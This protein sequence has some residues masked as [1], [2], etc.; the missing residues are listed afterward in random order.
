MVDPQFVN[1]ETEIR[2]KFE[3][4]RE[5][6]AK[7][8]FHEPYYS[9]I[10]LAA[11][12]ADAKIGLEGYRGTGKSWLMDCTLK[13]IKKYRPDNTP[14]YFR[15]QS[16][17]DADIEDVMVRLNAASLMRG[18]E[19]L[20]WK[21]AVKA[22]VKGFDEIQR[23]GVKALSIM[24]GMM[25]S[26]KVFY[27][28]QENGVYPFWAIFTMNPT[29][30]AEDS[31]NFAIPEPLIDRFD[32]MMWIPRAKMEYEMQIKSQEEM[33]KMQDEIPEIW[34]EDS[35]TDLWKITNNIPIPDNIKFIM[36][37]GCRIM[38]FCL[39]AQ[40]YDA[41]SL[42]IAKKRA[43]CSNCQKSYFCNQIARP[44]SI[45]ANQSWKKLAKGFA[46]LRGHKE[47]KMMDLEA[48]FPAIFWR[49]IS[50]MDEDFS[51]KKEKANRLGLFKKLWNDLIQEIRE[52]DQYFKLIADLKVKWTEEGMTKIEG[53]GN[54]KAWFTEQV[55]WLNNYYILVREKLN[56]KMDEAKKNKDVNLAKLVWFRAKG[57]PPNLDPFDTPPFTIKTVIKPDWLVELASDINGGAELFG[58]LKDN[59]GKET[60]L[61]GEILGSILKLEK[62][63]DK[64]KIDGEVTW[65]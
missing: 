12:A 61:E 5:A 48:S 34:D 23:L 53:F 39:F 41:T 57:I 21:S 14:L 42:G 26:G 7:V 19:E 3:E 2:A 11:M 30:T 60:V 44:P 59:S 28:E 63:N 25:D 38:S 27:M 8:F 51:E 55:D 64:L 15:V 35:L 50:L 40:D 18:D 6:L 20:I 9:E 1:N 29:E 36:D 22:R 46:Y 13:T 43:L 31:L 54:A 62:S 16:Y 52:S 24:F 17:L 37:L 58:K 4:T 45:R 65:K 47:V 49:R 32:A 56:D 33:K 10:V